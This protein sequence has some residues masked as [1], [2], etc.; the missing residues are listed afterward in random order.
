[1][2][3]VSWGRWSDAIVDSGREWIV[4]DG[5]ARG[6]LLYRDVVYWFPP[7]TPY[8]QAGLF[9]LLGSNFRT[10]AAAGILTAIASIAALRFALI[11]VTGRREALLWCAIAVPAL[12]FMPWGGGALIGMGYRIWQAAIF[13]LLAT[14][15]ATRRRTTPYLS[16]AVGA[17]SGLA[18][19]CRTEWGIASIAA[20]ILAMGVKGGWRRQET[21]LPWLVAILSAAGTFGAGVA[22]FV[23]AAG[24]DAVLRDGHVLLTGIPEETRRFLRNA[25]GVR[26]WPGGTLRM[27]YSAS[28]WTAAWALLTILVSRGRGGP[29][30][31]RL[32]PSLAGAVTILFL[33]GRYRG[34]WPM[35][36]FS[37]APLAGM[38]AAAVGWSRRGPKAA[39]LAAFGSLAVVLSYR[40]PFNIA[41]WPYV[42]PPLLF[43]I[44]AVAGLLRLSHAQAPVRVRRAVGHAAAG[45]LG[46]LALAFF[47]TR[48]NAYRHDPRIPIAGTSRLLH[49]ESDRAAWIAR[50]SEKIRNSTL[51][52][53]ALV[54]FPEGEVLNFLTARRNPLRHRLYLPGYLTDANERIVLEELRHARPAAIVILDRRTGEYGRP[55]FGVDYGRAIAAWIEASYEDA[56]L[57]ATPGLSDRLLLR[58]GSDASVSLLP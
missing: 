7:L 38:I 32:W 56:G 55:R 29:W 39:A 40:K 46:V 3:V 41:D 35:P 28:L 23:L 12:V 42:A 37:G 58:R 45:A 15:L 6:E 19:L 2:L 5:L 13:T 4:P 17:L 16:L 27:L 53:T 50:V 36:V 24:A 8:L 49:I 18:G 34:P 21:L 14:T 47:L 51:E 44:L 26:D 52:D 20:C 33:Y 54:V 22:V 57:A 48:A 43:G 1:L 11:R 30:T 9:R 31:R 10:L 25:S